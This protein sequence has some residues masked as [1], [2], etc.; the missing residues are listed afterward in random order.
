MFAFLMLWIIHQKARAAS[1][2]A[3]GK[4]QR[5]KQLIR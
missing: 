1:K 4:Q 5:S 3:L 2:Q